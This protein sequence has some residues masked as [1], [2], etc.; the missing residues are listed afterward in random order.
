MPV[1]VQPGVFVVVL[2]RQPDALFDV[3]WVEFL[4]DVVPGI[5]SGGPDDLLVL[6]G[7]C[8]RRAQMIAVVV[9]NG[10]RCLLGLLLF[11]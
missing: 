6:I 8:Q 5:E 11:F 3:V 7:E 2:P 1:V 10:D 9:A 4:L